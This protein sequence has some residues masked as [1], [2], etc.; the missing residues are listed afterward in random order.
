MSDL[1]PTPALESERPSM[2]GQTR[3]TD[4]NPTFPPKSRGFLQPFHCRLLYLSAH[5][6]YYFCLDLHI[7]ISSLISSS[8]SSLYDINSPFQDHHVNLGSLSSGA[9]TVR[10]SELLKICLHSQLQMGHDH[11][12]VVQNKILSGPVR[13]QII[14]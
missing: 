14:V 6:T 10:S 8:I 13:R 4:A 12:T 1:P 5:L 9:W 2:I 11:P 7:L 3:S